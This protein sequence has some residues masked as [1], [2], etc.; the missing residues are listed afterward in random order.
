MV[1]GPCNFVGNATIFGEPAKTR[2]TITAAVGGE[3][4]VLNSLQVNA[5][6]WFHKDLLLL[7]V[8]GAYGA[9]K[10]LCTALMAVQA[11]KKGK[12][13]LIVAVQNSALDV[14]CSK[15]AQMDTPDIHPVRYVNGMLARDALRTG[16]YDIA[17]IIE[18]LP[19]MHSDRMGPS[20]DAMFR[21]FTDKLRRLREF[22]FTSV[23]Q[24]LMASEHNTLLFL[25]EANSERVKALTSEFLIIYLPN[26]FICAIASAINLTTK[27]GLWRRPS[28]RQWDTVFLDEA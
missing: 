18:R 20:A 12:K 23:E 17:S 9:G 28:R 1:G 8:D 6:N 26:I 24:C 27:R 21:V 11:V 3:R 10:S 15:L 25:E 5:I 16:S 22:L 4:V 19:V 2:K 14:I 13:V 7:V